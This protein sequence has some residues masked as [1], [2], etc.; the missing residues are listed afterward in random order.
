MLMDQYF[1]KFYN[2][3]YYTVPPDLLIIRNPLGAPV[4]K[5]LF[6]LA[7]DSADSNYV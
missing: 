1:F 5:I 4:S 7:A 2:S 3:I 6:G